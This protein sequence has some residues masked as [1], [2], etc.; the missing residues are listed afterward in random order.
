MKQC[1]ESLLGSSFGLQT[2]PSV[3]ICASSCQLPA[4]ESIPLQACWF[5][6]FSSLYNHLFLFSLETIIVNLC[7]SFTWK[8]NDHNDSCC[9]LWAETEEQSAQF[10]LL[11]NFQILQVDNMSRNNAEQRST[12][13]IHSCIVQAEVEFSKALPRKSPNWTFLKKMFWKHNIFVA[14]YVFGVKF[15]KTHEYIHCEAF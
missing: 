2:D 3:C 9:V 6:Q 13:Q 4:V 8:D 11:W 7:P 14:F 5:Q 1:G 15:P 12:K 10:V